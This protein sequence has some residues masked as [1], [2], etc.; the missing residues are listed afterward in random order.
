[1]KY[2]NLSNRLTPNSL[3][4]WGISLSISVKLN[5]AKSSRIYWMNPF[6]KKMVVTVKNKKIIKKD[7]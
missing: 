4:R 5:Q 1:M 7:S 3:I 2:M 6:R